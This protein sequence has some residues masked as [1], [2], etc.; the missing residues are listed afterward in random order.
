MPCDYRKYPA[1]WRATSLTLRKVRARSVCECTGECG[2]DHGAEYDSEIADV[3]SHV[4]VKNDANRCQAMDRVDHPIT[5]SRVVLTVAHL[6][7]C[8]PLCDNPVHLKC[9][10]QRCHN[11]LDAPMRAKNAAKTRRKNKGNQDLFTI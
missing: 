5:Q 7:Q 11:K 1:T 2:R 6:C 3:L 10:C 4:N 8:E 9:L